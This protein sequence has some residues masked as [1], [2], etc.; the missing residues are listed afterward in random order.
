VCDAW[1]KVVVDKWEQ[2][3]SLN[4]GGNENLKKLAKLL[5]INLKILI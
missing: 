3:V 1:V 2:G 4:G 5:T